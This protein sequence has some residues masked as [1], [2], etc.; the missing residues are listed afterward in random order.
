MSIFGN[1][2]EKIAIFWQFLR[3]NGNI[4]AIFGHLNGI[5][6]EGQV[7]RHHEHLKHYLVPRICTDKCSVKELQATTQL[8]SLDGK[9]KQSR[10]L[11]AL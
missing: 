10:D 1:F 4:L 2:R 7:N 8:F 9:H 3:K 11:P 5:F 6:P